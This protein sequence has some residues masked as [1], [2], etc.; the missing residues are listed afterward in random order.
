MQ[1]TGASIGLQAG[2]QTYGYAMFFMNE[3]ALQQ[4]DAANGFEVGVVPSVV[5]AGRGKG[6]GQTT[7]TMKDDIYAF[8]FGQRPDGR[9]RDPGK[10]NLEDQPQMMSR[11]F[12]VFETTCG[13]AIVRGPSF[14]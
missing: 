7:T 8:I 9:T 5:D 10:Q 12:S 13:A 11:A 3:K 14:R 6:K 2:A 1:S 4:L